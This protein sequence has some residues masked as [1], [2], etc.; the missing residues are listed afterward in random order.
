[1]KILRQLCDFSIKQSLVNDIPGPIIHNQCILFSL[2][3]KNKPSMDFV[4]LK[5]R[6]FLYYLVTYYT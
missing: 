5:I 1:M 6:F 3:I 2:E 4:T